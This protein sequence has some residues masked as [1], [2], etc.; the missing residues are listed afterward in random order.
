MLA[1]GR[2]LVAEPVIVLLDEPSMG[3][4]P[5]MVEKI[6]E[7]VAAIGRSGTSILM[8]EQNATYALEIAHQAYVLEQGRVVLQG[9]SAEITS[10]AGVV[11]AFLGLGTADAI[12]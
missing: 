5:V 12:A 6:M 4:A 1:F 10:H 8:V 2:A 9:T 11:E 7:S 3:L